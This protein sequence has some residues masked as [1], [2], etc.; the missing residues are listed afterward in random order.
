MNS[1]V[2]GMVACYGIIA[3]KLKGWSNFEIPLQNMLVVGAEMG[4]RSTNDYRLPGNPN[5]FYDK[6]AYDARRVLLT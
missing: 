4:P 5:L 6:S 2:E 1:A 3:S